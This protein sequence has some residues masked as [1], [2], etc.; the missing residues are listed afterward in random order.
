[1]T[2]D[3]R[4]LRVVTWNIHGGV[5]TDRR[6]DIRRIGAVIGA[7][8]PDLA[9]FQEVDSRLPSAAPSGSRDIQ[10]YLRGTVGD[11]DHRAWALTGADGVYGQMLASRFP[12][13]GRIVHDISVAGREPRKVMEAIVMHP[14]GALRVLATHLGFR[15][16]ER[17]RQMTW[18][19]E[20][21]NN[22]TK[23]PFVLL[24][25]LNE[26]RRG[27]IGRTILTP[28]DAATRHPTF[29]SRFPVLPLDRIACRPGAMLVRSWV[30]REARKASDHLP[31]AAELILPA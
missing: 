11:H 23:T 12:L 15:Q 10:A 31:L 7:L 24:G 17:R 18:L 14:A 27:H 30:A 9:A 21:I 16:A 1:M 3:D 4:H 8:A 6:H 5:G 25:D 28:A 29:P 19:R 13:A 20:I 26:W 22:D 2:E